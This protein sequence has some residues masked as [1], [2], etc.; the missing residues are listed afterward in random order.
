DAERLTTLL[1]ER[2]GAETVAVYTGQLDAATRE[3]TEERLRRNDLKAVVST[4][5]LGMGFDKPDVGFV[6]HVGATPSPV[7]YYQQGGRAGRARGGADG[8]WP[9][10][11]RRHTYR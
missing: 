6:V 10:G 7:A 11:S 5:A 2:Y 9:R 1:A 3:A 8:L 4:S